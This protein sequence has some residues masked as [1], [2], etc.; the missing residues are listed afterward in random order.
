M[1]LLPALNQMF[2][3]ASTRTA[4]LQMHPPDAIFILLAVLALASALLAGFAMAG[5]HARSWLHI[6]GFALI[7]A[8]TVFFIL[9]LEFPRRGLIRV[10]RFDQILIDLR[11]SMR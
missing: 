5:R 11:Q 4:A 1:I 6:L 2:D 8:A 10:D 7:M 9:D 3:I